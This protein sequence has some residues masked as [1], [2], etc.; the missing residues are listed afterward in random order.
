M[1]KEDKGGQERDP[2]ETVRW[3]IRCSLPTASVPPPLSNLLISTQR[4]IAHIATGN[5][6]SQT[7]A[8]CPRMDP[9]PIPP[10]PPP[11]SGW[12]APLLQREGGK[13]YMCVW[14]GQDGFGIDIRQ[15]GIARH[16]DSKTALAPTGLKMFR[17]GVNAARGSK[18]GHNLYFYL[19]PP[20]QVPSLP[21]CPWLS[22]GFSHPSG[23]GE[24][25]LHLSLNPSRSRASLPCSL[26]GR[27]CL[28]SG[29]SG[30]GGRLTN[31]VVSGLRVA[32]RVCRSAAGLEVEN[33]A[34]V[35]CWC[36]SK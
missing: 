21:S 32:L 22:R 13:G 8:F 17:W 25:S 5:G 16:E 30:T 36:W 19:T 2:G 1:A 3:R 15:V 9:P 20:P 35:G 11:T 29:C 18:S 33:G 23:W 6:Y 26:W 24:A 14:G 4:F 7:V 27:V 12:L 34:R 28:E 10:S 31:T